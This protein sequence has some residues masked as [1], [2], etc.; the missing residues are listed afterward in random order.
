MIDSLR[1]LTWNANRLSDPKRVRELELFL[2]TQ[3]I[4]MAL[5]SEKAHGGTAVLVKRN[6]PHHET[7]SYQTM[8]IQASK[9][10]V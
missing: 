5:I 6:I 7:E 3:Q 2:Q 4:D 8:S 1:I 9:P 10:P